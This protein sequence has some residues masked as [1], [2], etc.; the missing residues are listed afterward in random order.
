LT[1]LFSHG[2]KEGSFITALLYF[3]PQYLTFTEEADGFRKALIDIVAFTFDVEGR[4]VDGS[5]K[6]FSIRLP[7]K[8]YEAVL[9][10]G[11]VST[12]RIPVRKPG[13]YQMRV[14]LRDATSQQLGSASQFIEAP[15]VK[16]GKLALSGIVLAGDPAAS[17]IAADAANGPNA[18]PAV[19]IFRPG[20]ATIVYAYEVINARRDRDKKPQLES[21]LRV[22]L[23]GK[24]IY[25]GAPNLLKSDAVQNPTRLAAAGRI[26]LKKAP[27]GNYVLQVI[28]KD[29]L[30]KKNSIAAQAMDFEIR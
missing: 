4:Q 11:L 29:N 19:R 30:A 1:T 17:T 3:D 13:A 21:Q 14:V 26:E 10:T 5:D 12:M 20:T 25:T 28:V 18:T 22:F 8:T 15:D 27:A 24:P 9:K 7:E 23:D 2:E 16:G 6:T